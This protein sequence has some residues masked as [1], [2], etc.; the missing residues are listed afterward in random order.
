MASDSDY[1]V[2]KCTQSAHKAHGRNSSLNHEFGLID[3]IFELIRPSFRF[4]SFHTI[5]IIHG[6]TISDNLLSSVDQLHIGNNN[7]QTFNTR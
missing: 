2:Y 1:T 7:H 3:A 5:Y 4:L 6:F